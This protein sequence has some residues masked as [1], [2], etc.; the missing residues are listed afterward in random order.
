MP[1]GGL[2]FFLARGFRYVYIQAMSAADFLAL[3]NILVAFLGVFVA[4]FVLFEWRKLRELRKEMQGFEERLT[5]KL[6]RNLKAAH[7]VMASY[8]LKNPEDRVALLESA[9][10]QDPSAFNAYNSLG[11]AYLDKNEI[12]KAIDAFSQAVSQHPDDKA[13]YC[14]LAYGYLRVGDNEL[15]LKYLRKAVSVDGTAQ[16]DIKNDPRMA[17]FQGKI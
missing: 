2:G 1:R 3:L 11:Y 9:V 14:D 17:A 16:D 5:Q 8:G 6:Y 10:A 4:G 12:Q 15:C 13:G 7:R